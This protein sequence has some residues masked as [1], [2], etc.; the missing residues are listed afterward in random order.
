YLLRLY[1][2]AIAT[3]AAAALNLVVAGFS[4]LVAARTPGKSTAGDAI[5]AP[6]LAGRR[7]A[8]YW[9]IAISGAT[10]LGAEVVWTRLLGMM[11]GSTVYV[12][13]IILAVFLIGLALGSSGGSLLLR[14]VPAHLALG[15][16]Q[17]L[18]AGGIAYA[19]YMIC[20]ALPY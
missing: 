14:K 18:L 3:Y 11:Y 15:W 17:I 4:L 7:T 6:V 19:V 5:A 1:D 13:S 9:T 10:A 16:T 12:F 2:T 8:V 20:N